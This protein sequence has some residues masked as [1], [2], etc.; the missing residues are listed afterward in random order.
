MRNLQFLSLLL[1]FLF[2]FSSCEK[3]DLKPKDEIPGWLRERITQDEKEIKSNPQSGLDIGAW[4][5]YR[6]LGDYY[7]EYHNLLS[8]SGPYIYDYSGI[9]IVKY[10]DPFSNY[11]ANKCCK[12]Y[13]WKGPAYIEY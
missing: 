12:Q 13:M 7:F 3:E 2:I 6:Y 8:S 10:Q 11:N 9:I 1:F 4:I 5:R